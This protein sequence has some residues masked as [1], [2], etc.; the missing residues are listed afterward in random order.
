LNFAG[1][2]LFL[3]FGVGSVNIASY[4]LVQLTAPSNFKIYWLSDRIFL[5]M[6]K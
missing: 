5:T 6:Y 1:A 2:P 4:L 3:S